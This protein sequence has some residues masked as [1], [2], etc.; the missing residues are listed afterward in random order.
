M[1]SIKISG[2]VEI[3]KLVDYGSQK[4]D[5]SLPVSKTNQTWRCL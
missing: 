4:N 3:A 1:Y 2:I 5:V